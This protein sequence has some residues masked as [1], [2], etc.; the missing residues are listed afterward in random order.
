LPTSSMTRR[1]PTTTG[2]H[3]PSCQGNPGLLPGLHSMHSISEVR[4]CTNLQNALVPLHSG[5]HAKIWHVSD[6]V[7]N[8]IQT[9]GG[10]E[11]G[12]RIHLCT[13]KRQMKTKA[14]T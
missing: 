13:R 2:A 14:G 3:N 5:S 10:G 9:N 11:G 8:E 6:N 1:T 4:H 7:V 12:E